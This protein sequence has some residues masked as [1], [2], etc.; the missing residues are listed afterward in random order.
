LCISKG[1]ETPL[2]TVLHYSGFLGQIIF[3]CGNFPDFTRYKELNGILFFGG[4]LQLSGKHNYFPGGP[5][6]QKYSLT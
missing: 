3:L 4:I 2:A 6:K 1:G 5:G